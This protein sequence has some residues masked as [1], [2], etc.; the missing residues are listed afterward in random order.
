M[1][2]IVKIVLFPVWLVSVAIE[3]CIV[4]CVLL[5]ALLDSSLRKC[6]EWEELSFRKEGQH[7]N[8]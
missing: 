5:L 7:E 2:A 4:A 3:V 6:P 8:D 1:K